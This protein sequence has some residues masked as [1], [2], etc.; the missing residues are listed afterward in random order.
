M[1]IFPAPLPICRPGLGLAFSLRTGAGAGCGAVDW[2]IAEAHSISAT[3][4][5][6]FD[7]NRFISALKQKSRAVGP[8]SLTIF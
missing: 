6:E 1:P 3:T 5:G 7:F 4:M 2:A 8:G